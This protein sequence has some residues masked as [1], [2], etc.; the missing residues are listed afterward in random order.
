MEII[1]KLASHGVRETELAKALGVDLK[2]W[3]RIRTDDEEARAAWQEAKEIEQEALVGMLYKRA[4]GQPAEYDADGNL[5]RAE[6]PPDA[7]ANMFLLK[8]RH[9][10]R[11]HG[12]DREAAPGVTVTITLRPRWILLLTAGSL[13]LSQSRSVRMH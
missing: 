6:I 4:M 1:R 7:T 9:G 2:T 11:D 5:L 10:Y 12:Q 3:V 13:T 8:T